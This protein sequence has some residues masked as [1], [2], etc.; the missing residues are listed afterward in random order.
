MPLWHAA[1]QTVPNVALILIGQRFVIILFCLSLCLS[2]SPVHLTDTAQVFFEE[3]AKQYRAMFER[4]EVR[5]APSCLSENGPTTVR[6]GPSGTA[7]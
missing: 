2:D 7:R 1:I 3:R 6:T 4:A 5:A